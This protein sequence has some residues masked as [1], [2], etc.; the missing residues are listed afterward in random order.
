MREDAYSDKYK[1]MLLSAKS[2][3]QILSIMEKIYNDGVDDGKK[4]GRTEAIKMKTYK[5][6]LNRMF[7]EASDMQIQDLG[8]KLS[9]GFGLWGHSI[10]SG[11][12]ALPALKAWVA[13]LR[14][15]GYDDLTI[16]IYG[17]FTDGRHIA[18]GMENAIYDWEKNGKKG[19]VDKAMQVP[20][21]KWAAPIAKIRKQAEEYF[22]DDF[23]PSPVVG[24]ISHFQNEVRRFYPKY[25]K[26][27]AVRK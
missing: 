27:L 21:E 12:Y 3:G 19:P 22:S 4:E 9:G 18:D 17:D 23:I 6:R 5:E 2:D 7:K 26:K 14:K 20:V 10:M 13:G 11:K 15:K 8:R 25:A 16:A 1:R 24:A